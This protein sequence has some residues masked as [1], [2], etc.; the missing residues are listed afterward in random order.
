MKG[1]IVHHASLPNDL[2]IATEKIL[3]YS[4]PKI[5]VATSTLA[6]GVNIGVS[7]VI[8]AHYRMTRDVITNGEFHNIIG[9]AGRS[10]IDVEG[11]VLFAIDGTREIAN[12][13]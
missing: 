3:R 10:F 12:G 8:I 11:R 13:K 1:I 7:T 6:Q 9:R 4:N 5:I 2:R